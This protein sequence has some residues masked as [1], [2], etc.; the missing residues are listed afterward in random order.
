MNTQKAMDPRHP[1][2][3][4]RV[5]S[6]F[7]DSVSTHEDRLDQFESLLKGSQFPSAQG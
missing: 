6:G 1:S 2:L 3:G 7:D 4:L 5:L